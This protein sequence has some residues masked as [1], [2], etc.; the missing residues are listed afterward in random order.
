MC[1]IANLREQLD[2]KFLIVINIINTLSKF[3]SHMFFRL[4]IIHIQQKRKWE[5]E[6]KPKV[7]K[8]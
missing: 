3:H 4:R 7:D 1:Y 6:E 8:R 5:E 2:A